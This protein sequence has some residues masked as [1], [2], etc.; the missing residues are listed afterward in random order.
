VGPIC[1]IVGQ[2]IHYICGAEGS[3]KSVF[4][5]LN[6]SFRRIDAMVVWFNQLKCAILRDKVLFDCSCCLIVHNIY[7]RS[8]LTRYSKIFLYASKMLLESRPGIGTAK[9]ALVS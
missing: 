1:P 8:L 4:E 7:L 3:D 9:M 6:R 2:G 5:R